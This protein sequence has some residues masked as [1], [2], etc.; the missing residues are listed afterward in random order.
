MHVGQAQYPSTAWELELLN[1]LK[2]N[3]PI[4]KQ[5]IIKLKATNQSG[6]KQ[7]T[8]IPTHNKYTGFYLFV[9]K[10]IRQQNQWKKFKINAQSYKC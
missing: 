2:S 8:D 10:Q 5:H 4:F 6:Q 3:Q 9:V 7:K 1:H